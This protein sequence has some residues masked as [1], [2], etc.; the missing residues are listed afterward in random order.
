METAAATAS[1]GAA[2]KRRRSESPPRDGEG[3]SEPK[4][5]RG[6]RFGGGGIGGGWENLD[7]VLSLQ[8][9]GLSLERKIELAVEFLT[10]QPNNSSPGHKAHSIQLSRLVAF[11]GNWVQSILNL[12]ENSKKML[13]RFDPALDSRCWIIL[14][15]CIE[16]KPS[17]SISL[18]LLKSLSRVARYG[19]SRVENDASYADDES[20]ELFERALDCML[21]LFSSNTRAFFN[22]GMDLWASCAIEVINLAQ[23]VSANEKNCCPV[24]RKLTNCLLGKFSSFMRF[25][26]NP[27][28]IFNTFVDKILEPLLELLVLLN[29]QANS[30]KQEQAGTMLKIVEDV[31]SNGLFHHH[32]L[33]GYFG[34]KNLTKTSATKDINASYH[35][36]LFEIFKG[37]KAENKAV[38]LAGFGYLLQLFVTRVRSQRT[39]SLSRLQKSSEGSEEPQHR[40]SF[41]EVFMQ[42]MEPLMLE[43]KLYSQKEFSNLGVT[44]LVEVHCMLKSVN[45]MLKTLIEEKIYIPTEDTSEGSYFNFLQHIYTVL[46][47]ISEKMYTF[48]VSAVHLED[49][50]IKKIVPLMFAEIIAAV[51]HFLEIE[52]KVLGDDLV[53][54]WLMIFSLS[55]INASCKDIKPSFLLAS[56]ISS[57]SSQMIC[58]FSELRQVSRS[59]FRLC[60]AVR[61]FSDGAT[62]AVNGSFSLASFSSQKRLESMTTLLSS[63]ALRGAIRTSIKSMPEGQSSRCIDELTQDLTETLK[64]AKGSKFEDA[65]KEQGESPSIARKSVFNQKAELLGRHLC[66]LYASVLESITVTSSNSTMVGKSVERL[67]NSIQPNFSHLVRKESNNSSEF[68]SSVMGKCLSKKQHTNWQKIPSASWIFALFFRL[69]ISCRSL[70]RQSISLMPP[71]VAVEATKLVGNPFI[72][73]SGR[74]WTNPANIR[75]EGYFAWIVESPSPL[76]DVIESL[77]QS[78]SRNCASFAPL[79]YSF[80]VMALQRLDDLNRQIEA[81]EYLLKDRVQKLMENDIGNTQLLKKSCSLEAARLTKF[82]M[83][84]VEN[85]FFECYEISGSWDLSLCSLD[86]GSFPIATWRL[87][88]DNIDIWGS[89]ASKKDLRNFFSCLIRF[90]FIRKIPFTKEENNSSQSSYRVTNLHDISVGLLCDTIIYDQKV[91]LK[92]LTSSFCHALKKS[93]SSFADNS[94]E[95]NALLDS[96]PDLMEIISNLENEKLIGRDSDAIHVHCIDKFWICENLLN[97]LSMVPGFHAN[98]KSFLRL[99]NY[100][101]HLERVVNPATSLGTWVVRKVEDWCQY[102]HFLFAILTLFLLLKLLGLRCESCNPMKLMHL[103][104]CCRRAMKNLISKF[105]KEPPESKQCLA[106]SETIVNSGSLVWF[107][108]SAQE[109]VGSSHKIFDVCT[110]EVKATIFSLVDKTSEL[111][112]TLANVNSLF[113]FLGYKKQLKSS[114]SGGPTENNTSEYDD[115][116]FDIVENPPLECVKSLAEWLQKTTTGIPVTVKD[117][118]CVI[119]LDNCREI[120]CWNSLACTMSCIGGFLW[121]LISALESTFRSNRIAGSD[122]REMMLQYYSK[123]SRYIAKFETFVDVCIHVLFMG[124]KDSGSVELISVRLPQ[125]L[126]CENGLLDIDAIMDEWTKYDLKDNENPAHSNGIPRVSRESLGFDLSNI[127]SMDNVLLENLL[128]GEHPLIAFTLR[129]VYNVSAI[130]KLHST[131]SFPS[132]VSRQTCS[133]VHQLSFGTMVGTAFITLQKIADMSSWPHMSSLVW[134]DRLLRYL[135]VLGSTFTLPELNISI[136]LYTQIVNAHL[137]AIGKCILL[138]GKNATLP[139]H[140][141]GSTTKTLQLQNASGCVLPKDLIDRQGRINSLKSRLR[142]LLRKFVNIASNIHLN[143]ALQVIERALVGVNQYSHSIYEIYTGNPEGGTISSDVAAGIDCLYLVLEF[144]PG[145]KR[146]FKR[147]VP[148][149]VGALFNIVLHLQSPLIFYIEKLPPHCS[150]FHPD[151]GAVVLMC[152]EVITS[153]VG[154]H[155]FQIDASHVSQ[156]LHV[157]VTL[158]KGF[159]HLLACRSIPRSSANYCN[160]SVRQHGDHSEYILDRRF[161]VDIYAAC[162]KLLCTTLRHQQREVGKCVALLEDSVSI[163][164]SCLESADSKMVNM[165]GYFA[166][167]MEEAIKCASFFRR[168]YEEMRQQREILGKHAMYFLA[169]YISIF[170]GQGPLQ[171]GITREIDEALRP[172]VY[173]LIDICEESDFQQLHT[174]LGE[175]PCRTTLADLVRDYKLHFQYQGKI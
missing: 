137:R 101:L 72:V 164:L 159:K 25:N 24:L 111:C 64:W 40:E 169:G 93:V 118:K 165:A 23:K 53:K 49:L 50:S 114:P 22:A 144:V 98:S 99:M 84:Y 155:S 58:T 81:F 21:L 6:P 121:G 56:K 12:P 19:L 35:R 52:Y 61:T 131:L 106:F 48:W 75:G 115:Q 70:Y 167:N 94:D 14:R 83:D 37:I 108:R 92:N 136:E 103:F 46:I 1:P 96:L 36:R 7:L 30:N 151:A 79:V 135:E 138:Q 34:L 66:E 157:P 59:I 11:I 65:S 27:K 141:I 170:S 112:S 73:C 15:V 173:S 102:E 91:L 117:S 85:Y 100:I 60:D 172:G 134:I 8:G 142:L 126:D 113:C 133:P 80:H 63:E 132:D 86:G 41:F 127:Q 16:M 166:W 67:V 76:L 17:I 45:V 20:F 158:F 97:F 44:K 162:C 174:Y 26:A 163:L 4:C 43:C 171:T 71:D 128:K 47:S 125:E 57:L 68:I 38:L 77:S 154:R 146:V 140:E 105:G 149:L 156:C 116:A 129:E 161:S 168:I 9:K 29:S 124:N 89:H 33:S 62:D 145:N 88:C 122:E 160:Q 153:F 54:L 119:K 87:L 2:R 139:T 13:Q 175:G 32:H 104:I 39:T 109:I 5:A 152:V 130:V 31:L 90:S 69:Y 147:T 148:G 110:D 143:A 10:T 150:E 74:E 42:F 107:L 82:M 78:L 18:N 123:F 120:V 95:Y 51:C 28:N 3:P 55:A